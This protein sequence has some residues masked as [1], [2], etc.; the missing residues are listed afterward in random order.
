MN[1]PPEIQRE[2]DYRLQERL[3]ILCGAA[4]PTKEQQALAEKEAWDA[5]K[6]L[7]PI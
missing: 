4:E 7:W 5:I 2:F 1:L 6:K 3:G